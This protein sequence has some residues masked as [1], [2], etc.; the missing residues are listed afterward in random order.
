MGMKL[1]L[2][3]VFICIFLTI[4]DIEHIFIYLSAFCISSVEKYLFKSFAHFSVELSFLVA[5]FQE[6]VYILDINYFSDVWYANISSHCMDCFFIL[7][8]MFFDVQKF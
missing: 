6:F 2:I 8:T 7:L 1:Y 4:S 5:E 3:V